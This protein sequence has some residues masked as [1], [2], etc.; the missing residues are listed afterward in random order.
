MARATVWLHQHG[1][2]RL[3]IAGIRAEQCCETTARHAS[4]E[5]FEVDFVSD[6]TLSFHIPLADGTLLHAA[7]IRERTAAVPSGRVATIISVQIALDRAP[8]LA[9]ELA[10]ERA[11]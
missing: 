2:R 1:T 9:P 3:I 10:P 11:A 4:D 8:E 6:A 7:Q 5:G